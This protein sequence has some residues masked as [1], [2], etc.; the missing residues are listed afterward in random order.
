MR[1]FLIVCI[2]LIWLVYAILRVA[3]RADRRR[4][5]MAT[6][7]HCVCFQKGLYCCDCLHRTSGVNVRA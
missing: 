3:A 6:C 5:K 7:N 4:G 1:I 2:F